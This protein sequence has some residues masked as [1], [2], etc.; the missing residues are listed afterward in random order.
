MSIKTIASTDTS[1]QE[2]HLDLG[3]L[4]LTP[5]VRSDKFGT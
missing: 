4:S 2:S 1:F 5:S 3:R